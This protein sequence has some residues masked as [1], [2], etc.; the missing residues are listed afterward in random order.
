MKEEKIKEEIYRKIKEITEKNEDWARLSIPDWDKGGKKKYISSKAEINRLYAYFVDY[1]DE[2]FNLKNKRVL[3]LG[4]GFGNN[5][6]VIYK[7]NA[8]VFALDIERDF[9]YVVNLKKKLTG[10]NLYPLVGDGF[11][12]PFKDNSFD[13]VVCT[14][15]LEHIKNPILFLSEIKR[16]L[17]SRGILYL[18][19]PNYFFPFEP[20]FRVFSLPYLP[21]KVSKFLLKNFFYKNRLKKINKKWEDVPFLENF[22]YELNFMKYYDIEKL[23]KRVGFKIF[24]KNFVF[25][26]EL[27]PSKK[28]ILKKILKFLK[29]F[30]FETRFIAI[31]T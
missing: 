10:Y 29:F 6:F 23:I 31:K 7:K 9:I 30:P 4:C 28:L 12:L 20:H 25:K 18:S 22:L 2:L 16:V 1:L 3:D 19:L 15:T 11:N 13:L 14:H 17:K 27:K 5:T 26:E 24:K 21:K 8:I